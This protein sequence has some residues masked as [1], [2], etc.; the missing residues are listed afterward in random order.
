MPKPRKKQIANRNPG[1]QSTI[2]RIVLTVT[3]GIAKLDAGHPDPCRCPHKQGR[4][5]LAAGV[6]L[7]DPQCEHFAVHHKTN[8][9]L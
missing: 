8:L 1:K 6:S 2:V 4:W 9:C 7:N 3:I 5:S